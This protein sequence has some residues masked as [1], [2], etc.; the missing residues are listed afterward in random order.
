M[1]T[2]WL[3]EM[4]WVDVEDYLKNNDIILVPVGSTEQH[5][6][7]CPLGLDTYIAIALAEDV[8][9]KTGVI[10][11]PPIWFGDSPHH[12]KFPGTISLRTETLIEL[13]KDVIR[14]LAKHGFKKII[15]INGHKVVNLDALHA[16]IRYMKEYECPDVFLAVID[17][18]KLVSAAGVRV[19]EEHHG[20]ALETS[21]LWYKFPHLIRKDRLTCERPD[22]HGM[23]SR[24]VKTDLF[25]GGDTIDVAWSSEEQR[26]F[27]SSGVMSD[28]TNAS[29]E[30]GREF[31]ERLVT[32][33]VEFIE[34]LKAKKK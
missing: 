34:W 21:H 30:L 25:A 27:T 7:A 17:P 28:Q 14:S 18:I 24:F 9:L 22:F 29:P 10:S 31:H 3:N 19:S 15:F 8:A 32:L 16:A 12:L 6:P 13:I 33:I 5:G 26:R 2:V 20:G 1:K 4:T 11:T 23:F